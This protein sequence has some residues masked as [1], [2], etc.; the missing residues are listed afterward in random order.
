MFEDQLLVCKDCG[1]EY[2]F[3]AEEQELY[4][5]ARESESSFPLFPGRCRDC[6]R[7]NN[8]RRAAQCSVCGKELKFAPLSS[9]PNLKL[10]CADC[11][12]AQA[13]EKKED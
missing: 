5:A 4:A 7:K 9:D 1:K 2:I 13:E 11:F 12:A 6:R 3:T 8:P 10:L